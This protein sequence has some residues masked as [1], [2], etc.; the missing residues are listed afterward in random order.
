[1]RFLNPQYFFGNK[2]FEREWHEAIQAYNAH[3]SGILQ[4]L[5]RSVRE[6]E[7]FT[8]RSPLHD[9]LIDRVEATGRMELRVHLTGLRLELI[10]VR[11]SDCSVLSEPTEWLYEELDVAPRGG[12]FLRGFTNC[13]EVT[14]EA[15]DLRLFGVSERRYLIPDNP[16]PAP[17]TLFLKRPDGK[18]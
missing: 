4:D 1:M 7:K 11:S 13:G 12:F 15:Q 2:R 6:F 3:L 8:R 5:P 18:R 16:P 10:G 9:R 14:F 17:P